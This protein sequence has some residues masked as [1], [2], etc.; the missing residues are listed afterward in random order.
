[1]TLKV[2]DVHFAY[3]KHDVL[4]KIGFE[5]VSGSLAAILG[6]NGSGKTTLLKNINRILKPQ[7]GS[8]LIDDKAVA[9]MTRAI[10]ARHFGYV[11]QR[12]QSVHCTVFEAVLLGR[13][14]RADGGPDSSDEEKVRDILAL[15]H[16]ED[17]AMRYTTEISGGELQRVIIAR[18]LAQEPKVLLL[19]EP[20]NHLD[21]INQI[22]VMS[23]IHSVTRE[24]NITSLLVTH[25][26]N[27]ALRFADKFILL[28]NGTVFAC[29]G[30][31]IITPE[32]VE[33]VFHIETIIQGIAGIPV[34]VPLIKKDLRWKTDTSSPR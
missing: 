25:D 2:K 19:D 21:P 29:G 26:L 16:L 20:I 17:L 7:K 28:K 30:K 3:G 4:E 13:K 18:A 6:E 34:V 31:E 33:A 22:E 8:V 24:M 9:R 32:T 5:A 10:I 14:V 12:S 15:L 23:L 11:P 1:M 27:N